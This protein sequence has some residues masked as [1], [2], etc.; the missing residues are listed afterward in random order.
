MTTDLKTEKKQITGRHKLS[1][2]GPGRPKGKPNKFTTLKQAFLDAFEKMGGIEALYEWAKTNQH[3]KAQFYQMIAK[4]LPS[5][6][7]VEA[8]KN[9]QALILSITDFKKSFDNLKENKDG[10]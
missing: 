4:M 10:K 1:G 7:D 2:P 3:T 6:I 9:L 8:G 5:N